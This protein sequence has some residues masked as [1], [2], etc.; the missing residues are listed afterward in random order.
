MMQSE[1]RGGAF[2]KHLA[3][4]ML[5][6]E[7]HIQHVMQQGGVGGLAFAITD[8]ERL[9]TVGTTGFADIAAQRPVT[10][11]TH[12]AICSITKS[13]T[14]L[15]IMQLYE[16]G[17][18]DIHAPITTYLPW[19]TIKQGGT[20][21]ITVY[22]LLSHTA[23]IIAGSG[24]TLGS[25]YAAWYL[26]EQGDLEAGLGLV[27]LMT[28]TTWP[29]SVANYALQLPRAASEDAPLPDV[30]APTD[31]ERTSDASKYAGFFT[32]AGNTER[33]L[34]FTAEDNR[35]VLHYQ[36]E[37]IALQKKWGSQFLIPH[38]DFS[39]FL[40]EF[41]RADGKVIEF[42]HGGDW[43][44]TTAYQ[45]PR[46]FE[47]PPEWKAYPGHYCCADVWS[48]HMRVV[49][50]KGSLYLVN[51]EGFEDELQPQD[52]GSFK[53]EQDH[54]HFHDA[55]NGAALRLNISGSEYTRRRNP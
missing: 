15:A 30:P 17:L 25:P 24:W 38:P 28:G 4:I 44:V 39:R 35:L 36:G 48:G 51:P 5:R 42:T 2:L 3:A 45:G 46:A 33:A 19:C 31:P 53:T 14:A 54:L 41:A 50:R 11:E 7:Q 47:H 34:L 21:P 43:Y 20:A 1:E 49:L 6:L 37:Q 10:P 40:G 18:I 55:L 22:H 12:F 23:N 32:H 16:Q 8:R 52:D 13:F 29:S 27:L 26:R 9:L